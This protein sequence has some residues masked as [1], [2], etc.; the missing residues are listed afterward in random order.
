MSVHLDGPV[1]L[2]VVHRGKG[3]LYLNKG[4]CLERAGRGPLCSHAFNS[5]QFQAL[6]SPLNS[7]D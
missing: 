4:E 5:R 3:R 2:L 1:L 7:Q 6:N